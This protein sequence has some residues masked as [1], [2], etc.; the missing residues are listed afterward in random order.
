S[1]PNWIALPRTLPDELLHGLH[2][3]LGK[4]AGQRLDGFPFAI[5]KQAAHVYLAP[6]APLTPTHRFQQVHKKLL[7]PLP[8]THRL[9]IGHA[10]TYQPF[11]VLS[12]LNAVILEAM[13]RVNKDLETTGLRFEAVLRADGALDL[14]LADDEGKESRAAR[15][16]NGVGRNLLTTSS[17][18]G[19]RMRKFLMAL[20]RS[21]LGRDPENAEDIGRL[22][23]SCF[24]RLSENPESETTTAFRILNHAW[25]E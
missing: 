8:T 14:S 23:L 5:Q 10:Q 11:S 16:A 7:Q 13:D 6:M 15:I 18:T 12:I 2:V 22:W 24:D 4:P 20:S 1:L 3:S 19:V 17:D 9:G 25:W 21:S